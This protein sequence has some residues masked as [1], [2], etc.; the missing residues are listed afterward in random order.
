MASLLASSTPL[1]SVTPD[2]DRTIPTSKRHREGLFLIPKNLLQI[3][4]KDKNYKQLKAF[5]RINA[6]TTCKSAEHGWLGAS[7]SCMEILTVFTL[8]LKIPN[9]IL[10]KGHAAAGQYAILFADGKLTDNDLKNYKNGLN[11]LEAHAD[12]MMDTGSL[13]QCLSSV[14]GMAVAN[15][16]ET[17]VVILGDGEMQEGQIYEALMTIKKYKI[18]NLIA[19]VDLNEFQSDNRCNEIMPIHDFEFYFNDAHPYL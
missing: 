2:Q 19:I 8:I 16:N 6:L 3:A 9:I 14:A 15:R 10:A 13:G 5:N 17:Y 18:K 4:I 7:Y 1:V 12:L 11:G